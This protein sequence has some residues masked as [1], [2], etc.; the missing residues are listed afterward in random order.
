[1]IG[2]KRALA[3]AALLLALPLAGCFGKTSAEQLQCPDAQSAPGLENIAI[4]GPGAE[5]TMQNVQIAGKIVA[6]NRACDQEKGGI[7]INAVISFSAGRASSQVRRVEFPYFVAVVD[8]NQT[9]LN[10][11]RFTVPLAFSGSD[12][13]TAQEKITIHLPVQRPS[14]GRNFAVLVGFQL[15][16]EQRDFNR[17]QAAGPR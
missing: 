3:V 4:F 5:R 8:L 11:Q 16:D 14:A 9:I 10:E 12:F 2:P 7:Q 6:V 1:M 13:A 15:T 17:S